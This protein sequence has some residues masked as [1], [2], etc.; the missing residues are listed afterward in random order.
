[1]LERLAA[2]AQVL[3]LQEVR[4]VEADL[5]FLP[6]SHTYYSSLMQAPES[7]MSS[8]EGG[9]VVAVGRDLC[10][11]LGDIEATEI[12]RGR[13]LAVRMQR[14]PDVLHVLNVHLDPSFSLRARAACLREIRAYLD[15]HVGE[16]ALIGGGWNFVHV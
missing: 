2:V 16:A 1:M 13:V 7:G 9:V 5:H 12:R 4:G 3:C 15:R 11:T 14:G 8:R 10:A 6:A